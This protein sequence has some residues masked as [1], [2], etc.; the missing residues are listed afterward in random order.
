M[1][2]MCVCACEAS[3]SRLEVRVR[4][5]IGLTA[6]ARGECEKLAPAYNFFIENGILLDKKDLV[7]IDMKKENL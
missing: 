5:C 6:C 4:I 3:T 7:I 1:N 2:D